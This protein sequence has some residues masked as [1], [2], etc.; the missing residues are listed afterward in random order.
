MSSGPTHT[1]AKRGTRSN[2]L[3]AVLCM[4]Q[5]MLILD[6]AV[7][8]VAVPSIQDDLRVAPVDLQWISSAYALAFGGFLIVAGRGADLLG[9]RR[10]FL[11]G[12]LG[13]V[14]ASL[15][16]GMAQDTVQLV[17]ARGAQGLAAAV[18]SPAALALLTGSL[19]EGPERN[20]ALGI[21]GAVASGGAVAGQLLGGLITD[22]LDWRWIFFI[23]VPVGVCVIVLGSKLLA[24]DRPSARARL[25]LAGAALLTGGLVLVVFAISNLAERGLEITEIAFG[26]GGLLALAAFVVVERR[27]AGRGGD[28]IVRFG[29]FENRHVRYGNLICLLSAAAVGVVIFLTTLY[30]QRVLGLSPLQVGLGFAPVTLAIAI[31][32]GYIARIIERLGLRTT[33]LIGNLLMTAGVVLLAFVSADGSYFT[34]ALPGLMLVGVGSGFSYA[35]AMI[36]ATTGV[37]EGE[38]GLA[39]GILNTSFQVGGALGVAILVSVAV[40]ATDGAGVPA[41]EALTAGYRAG[42]RW[43]VALPLLIVVAALALP[44][45]K[46]REGA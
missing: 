36:A 44:V 29:L 32:S 7:V 17:L 20:R 22:L 35:P 19:A 4:A 38:Q 1:D 6:V 11:A 3:L 23:N 42:F 37:A 21:W 10:V 43:A 41:A 39:S 45:A 2:V 30:L 31:V 12:V 16:C 28:P 26:V 27:T 14:V 40:A 13:F 24:R 15:G 9:A 46:P 18:V 33:L 5:F 34:H 25:D 8:A